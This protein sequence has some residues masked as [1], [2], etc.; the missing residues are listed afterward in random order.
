MAKNWYLVHA[1]ITHWHPIPGTSNVG[2]TSSCG[3]FPSEFVRAVLP[4]E[5]PLRWLEICKMAS[6]AGRWLD[7][8]SSSTINNHSWGVIHFPKTINHY[9]TWLHLSLCLSIFTSTV[10]IACGRVT[11][12]VMVE[13]SFE[14]LGTTHHYH[15]TNIAS[16]V[17]HLGRFQCRRMVS[18]RSE[19]LA[20]RSSGMDPWMPWLSMKATDQQ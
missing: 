1:S 4:A 3:L 7:G 16:S 6:S 8:L 15:S 18:K 9:Y 10:S 2:F 5:R 11:I 19:D 20:A 14:H 17:E 13:V 12:V